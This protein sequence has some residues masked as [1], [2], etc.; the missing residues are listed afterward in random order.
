MTKKDIIAIYCGNSPKE[1]VTNLQT[2]LFDNG[3][4]WY[5]S[6]YVGERK[7]KEGITDY[8]F[9]EN[10]DIFVGPKELLSECKEYNIKL[11]N[12]PIEYTRYYKIRKI[13]TNFE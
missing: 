3:Y 7:Y 9:I 5:S 12:S 10:S 4:Q 2:H 8:I 1:D 13:K 6:K 11:F